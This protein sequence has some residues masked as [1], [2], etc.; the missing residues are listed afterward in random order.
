M[1]ALTTVFG[2]AL[3]A[4]TVVLTPGPNMAYLVSRSVYEGRRAGLVS[5]LGVLAAFSVYIVLTCA[6]LTALLVTVPLAY[7]ALRVAG[8]LYLGYLA[9]QTLKPG[10]R[11]PFE[12]VD[13]P[14]DSD[15]KLFVMG[16]L[17][18][19]LN[20]KGA[21][22]YLV[23]P[24]SV[25]RPSLGPGRL[26]D[27]PVGPAPNVRQRHG[28]R[29]NHLR[30]RD[31]LRKAP[32]Q[33]NPRQ[34]PASRDGNRFGRTGPETGIR[35]T[36]VTNRRSNDKPITEST[37][38]PF[39]SCSGHGKR[40]STPTVA[41]SGSRK[42]ACVR[43]IFPSLEEAEGLRQHLHRQETDIISIPVTAVTLAHETPEDLESAA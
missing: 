19:L 8:T 2:F 42:R 33:R 25:H 23:P 27:P 40:G 39:S 26:A 14:P 21:L 10:G 37:P 38:F 41:L 30:V 4:L 18:N 17:A 13:L 6:G 32:G 5:L 28:Q 36:E 16:F 11:T 29:P 43:E 20:P 12:V 24:P 34:A 31:H 35:L 15:R 3:V 1:L 22:L 7:T 9:Y